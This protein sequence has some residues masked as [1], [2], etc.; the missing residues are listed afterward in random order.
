MA[1]LQTI[2]DNYYYMFEC[3]DAALGEIGDGDIPSAVLALQSA[4]QQAST[5][6]KPSKLMNPELHKKKM[7][8][9]S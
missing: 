6:I 9:L 8:Q 3:I 1:T 2:I 7:E 5:L 4:K